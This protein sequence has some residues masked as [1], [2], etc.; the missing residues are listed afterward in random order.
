MSPGGA[1]RKIWL[2]EPTVTGVFVNVTQFVLVS[3]ELA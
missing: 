1:G 3:D 2:R